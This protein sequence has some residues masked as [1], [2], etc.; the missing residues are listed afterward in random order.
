MLALGGVKGAPY[1]STTNLR[2]NV[3]LLTPQLTPTEFKF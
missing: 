3:P 1:F 2:P